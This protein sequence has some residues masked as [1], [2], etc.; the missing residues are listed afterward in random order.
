MSTELLV[1]ND[2]LIKCSCY[3]LIEEVKPPSGKASAVGILGAAR[4]VVRKYLERSERI[5]NRELAR[6]QFD[7]YLSDV[8]ELEPTPAELKLAS[9]MEERA[10][11]DGL[12]LD[13]G[14]SQLCAVAISRGVPLILTGDKRAIKAIESVRQGMQDIDALRGRMVCLEQAIA[15]IAQRIGANVARDSICAEP[16]IDKT[17]SIC[18]QCTRSSAPPEFRPEGLASYVSHLRSEAPT[19]LYPPPAL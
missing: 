8:E 15:G 4:F 19:M 13:G 12:D 3:A 10:L 17:L 2:V 7:Q 1:D 5:R 9:E 14:E 11:L 16:D 6:V 18:F